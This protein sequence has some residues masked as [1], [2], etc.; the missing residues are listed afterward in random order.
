MVS[1]GPHNVAFDPAKIP[2][3]AEKVLAANMPDQLGV[4]VGP[5]LTQPNTNYTVS[6]AGVPPGTYDYVCT[7]H[8]MMGMV[9]KLTVQ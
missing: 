5:Y 2:D 4:L 1:G 8:V 9:G 3:D 6:F 7:P